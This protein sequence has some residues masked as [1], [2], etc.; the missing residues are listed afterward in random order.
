MPLLFNPPAPVPSLSSV[1]VPS[2][3]GGVE[4][5]AALAVAHGKSVVHADRKWFVELGEATKVNVTEL[6]LLELSSC[7]NI[8][9][10]G[11]QSAVAMAALEDRVHPVLDQVT[12]SSNLLLQHDSGLMKSSPILSPS[13]RPLT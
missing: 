8:K 10:K 6:E 1:P 3:S 13:R 5:L 11:F 12:N 2:P 4:A 7:P 9:K